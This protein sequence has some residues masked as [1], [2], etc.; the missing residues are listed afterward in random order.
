[1]AA[2]WGIITTGEILS[3]LQG[4]LIGGSMGA[5][6]AG[7]STD[8]RET[9][10]GSLFFA[11]EGEKFNGHDFIEK[12]VEKGAAGVVMRKRH[13]PNVP[14][15]KNVAVIA[16]S[17]TLKALG[18]LAGWWRRRHGVPVAAITGSAG[19]TTT[20]EMAASIL[21]LSRK[22]LKNKGNF[23]N[24]VGL[25]LTLLSM[26]EGHQAAVLEMGMNRPGEIARLTEIA[27]PNI[28]LITNVA[29]AHLEGLGS[30]M[31]VA[32]A[33]VEL[34]EK[35]A[36]EGQVILNGDDD[37]LMKAAAPF[38]RRLKT[39][40]MGI[41]NDFRAQNLRTL[42]RAGFS[43]EINHQG[44][45]LKISLPVPGLQNVYN[46]LAAS[47]VAFCLKASADHI[48]QGLE[49]FE[50]M[51]GRFRLRSLSN[52]ATLVDDTYNANPFSLKAALSSLKDLVD[53]SGRVLVGLGEMM[54]L[55]DETVPAHRE[56]GG[57]VADSGAYYFVAMGEHAREMIEGAVSKGLPPERAVV[58]VTHDEMAERLGR[59]TREKDLIFL[60]GSRRAGL[61]K[62]VEGLTERY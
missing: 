52:G 15:A 13:R 31:G 43:F 54:E 35:M 56:A 48:V 45:T 57:M 10:S 60:K 32:K 28:G 58:V 17:D 23:N 39:Y 2:R 37:V 5:T 3:A 26:E 47:A 44:K 20:K 46:A 19:K 16:V 29:K 12:A 34:L 38:G 14:V 24:L 36:P 40:G 62:V 18:D 53:D 55:G 30:V 42:G 8:S 25:P 11:L 21:A 4:E 6:F 50:G 59:L 22:I 61:E 41:G 49:H 1:M 9:V 7:L 33:K 27:D 51:P